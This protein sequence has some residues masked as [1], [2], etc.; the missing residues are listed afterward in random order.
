MPVFMKQLSVA[1]GMCR[2]W[3]AGFARH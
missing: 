1:A 2:S 3:A